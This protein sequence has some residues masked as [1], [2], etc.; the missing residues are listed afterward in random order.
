MATTPLNGPPVTSLAEAVG[1]MAAIRD[2]L[3]ARNGLAN[4]NVVYLDVTTEV[5]ARIGAAF[6]ADDDFMTRFDVGFVNRYL[7]AVRAWT[8]GG[9]GPRSWRALLENQVDRDIHPA[10]FAIAGMNAHINYDL[11]FALLAVCRER[12][13]DVG[14]GGRRADYD[15]VNQVLAQVEPAMRQRFQPECFDVV[16]RDLPPLGKVED[17]LARFSI[18]HARD[19]AWDEAR[20]LDD[21]PARATRLAAD[22]LDRSV[23]AFGHALLV[24][25]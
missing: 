25:P 3:P 22:L 18:E 13:E 2:A 21:L 10:Q 20:L 4:F 12:Q 17:V 14:T 6:F 7:D 15:R 1:R 24:H 19:Q 8:D 11:P 16:D 23:A 9:A 5:A